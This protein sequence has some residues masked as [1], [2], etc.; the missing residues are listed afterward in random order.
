MKHL[1]LF[2]RD[3]IESRKK[4]NPSIVSNSIIIPKFLGVMLV[5]FY[6]CFAAGTLVS[7]D[8]ARGAAWEEAFA[9]VDKGNRRRAV[10]KLEGLLKTDYLRRKNLRFIMLSV[11]TMRSYGI[12]RKQLDTMRGSLHRVMRWQIARSIVS[13]SFMKAW[14][15]AHVR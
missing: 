15:I 3:R 13:L 8:E 7:A 4:A 10:S 5:L 6:S 12:T 9:L 2:S 1:K 14:I 11:I